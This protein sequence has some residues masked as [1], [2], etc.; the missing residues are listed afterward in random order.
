ML[1]YFRRTAIAD[2]PVTGAEWDFSEE[3]PIDAAAVLNEAARLGW[4]IRYATDL[5]HDKRWLVERNA[6][7]RPFVWMIDESGTW[8]IG[9]KCGSGGWKNNGRCVAAWRFR[10]ADARV[11]LWDGHKLK[12]RDAKS[13]PEL[14]RT[15]DRWERESYRAVD[16][17]T[18]APLGA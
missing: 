14:V 8:L 16:A 7:D 6:P 13:D 12:L 4:P 9:D 15:I 11:Y 1:V 5:Q 10:Q 3:L 18:G 17:W 2:I